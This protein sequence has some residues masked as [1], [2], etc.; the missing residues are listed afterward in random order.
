MSTGQTPA[1][2]SVVVP[3]YNPGSSLQGC[4]DSLLAQSM[5]ADRVELIFVDDGSTDGTGDWLDRLERDHRQVV[6]IHQENSGWAG[7][8]RN[9]GIEAARGEFVQLVDQ[10]DAL[11]PE[12][13]ERLYRFGTEHDADIVIGKVTSDF[14]R[15]PQQLFRTN[16][17]RCSIHDTPLVRS[18]TPHKMFRRSFLLEHGLRFAEGR[19][20]LEDQLF[21]MQTYFATDAVA[22]LADYPC[23]LYLRREDGGNTAGTDYDPADYYTNLREV[24]DVVEANTKPGEFR[25]GLHERFLNAML[26]KLASRQ[27][28]RSERIDAYQREIRGVVLDRFSPAV[29]ERPA[30]MRRYLA[31]AMLID[32]PLK[33]RKLARMQNHLKGRITATDIAAADTGWD[34]SV[35]AE[36]VHDDGSP[37]TLHRDGSGWRLDDRLTVSGVT[38]RTDTTEQLMAD[39]SG[40]L[41]VH[42][43]DT[44]VEWLSAQ[45]YSPALEPIADADGAHHLVVRG[46][47]TIDPQTFAAG[48]P[49]EPGPWLVDVRVMA[50]GAGRSIPVRGAFRPATGGRRRGSARLRYTG[51]GRLKLVMKPTGPAPARRRGR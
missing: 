49:L 15:V 5:A 33:L 22:I 40:E 4:V 23:Y 50:L 41:V 44:G 12:A 43:R 38:T 37:V 7:K 10:D 9:V 47:V 32:R 3:V 46:T 39:A 18:L 8:P 51:A 48:S 35:T 27:R 34:I 26:R 21:M 45:L 19:R 13:L 11:G 36:L 30:T 6:V 29:A 28:G 14:R 16:I 2:V 24:L 1:A 25:D 31:A 20:R 17:G 42:S